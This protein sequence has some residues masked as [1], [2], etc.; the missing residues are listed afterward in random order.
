MGE[1]VKLA[2]YTDIF[3]GYPFKSSDY[4][5]S[6]VGVRLL[7]GDNIGHGRARWDGAK[8]WPHDETLPYDQYQLQVGDVV[9]AMD[10]P[11]IAAGLKYAEIRSDDVPSL[12]VQRVARLRAHRGLDQRFLCYLLGS[13]QFTNHVVCVQTGT[14]IPHISS[15]QIG[16]FEFQRPPLRTQEEIAAILGA[17]D[18]KIAIN[19]QIRCLLIEVMMA[20]FSAA[21]RH[22]QYPVKLQEIINLKYGKALI[23]GVR[24]LGTIPVYGGN[25]ISGWHQIPLVNRPGIIIG[26]KGANA[27]SV[28]WSQVPFWP[29][30]TA[31]YVEPKSTAVPNEFLFFLLSNLQ[32]RHLVGDSAIPG[33]N[34]DVTLACE[35]LLPESDIIQ[36]FSTHAGNMLIMQDQINSESRTLA[37][38]RDTLLPKLMSGELRVRDA[39]MVVE[40]MT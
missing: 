5:D 28:S 32:L 15:R 34:R 26:R 35:I 10:R 24:S 17:L 18:D 12:L 38:L 36:R 2:D 11:W 4:T 7:R 25:G 22:A 21:M 31:F 23:E 13:I 6:S 3:T 33:L 37:Q 29:I 9:V 16:A 40:E 27:G 20:H 1:I 19:E 39:E 8:Y 30:D 14:A